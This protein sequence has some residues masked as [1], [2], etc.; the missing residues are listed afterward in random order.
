MHDGEA[1]S[2][3]VY[4]HVAFLKLLHMFQLNLEY[5]E[6]INSLKQ[7]LFWFITVHCSP[8]FI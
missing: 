4:L 8:Y 3:S 6:T 7:I 2:I 5:G 1:M